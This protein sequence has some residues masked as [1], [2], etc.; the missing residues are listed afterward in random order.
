MKSCAACGIGV[1]FTVVAGLGIT[2]AFAQQAPGKRNFDAEIQ[3]A[4]QSAKTAAGFEH[5]GTLVRT[6]LLPQSGGENTSD[7]VPPYV[8]K[9]ASARAR[10]TWYADPARVFDNLYFVGGKIHSSWALTTK[11]GIILIDTIYPYNSGELIIGGMKKLGLDPKNIKYVLVS[12]AHADHIGGAE[13]LQ[14]RY[15]ARVVM[16]GPDWDWVE[17]YTNRYKTM[18]PQ[19]DIV[20]TDGMKITLGGTAVTIWLTPGHTPGTMSYTF[21]VWDRGKP[22]TVAYSGG[23]AFN[24]VNNTPDPGIKNFQT[25]I[26][27]QKHMAT[28]AASTGATVLLSNHSEFDN[29]FNKNRMLAGRGKGP[30]PYEIGADWVQR[31]FQVMQGCARAAQLRLEQKAAEGMP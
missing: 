1:V 13:M 26:D 27:S 14:T 24:F 8:T 22:V 19:R 11:A 17:K 5:L 10:S 28:E 18:A 30:H 25:Y 6:C 23:T 16:G 9:P 31:Y 12:H 4:L 3:G 20:A 2:G 7:N 21:T 29:A 15:K